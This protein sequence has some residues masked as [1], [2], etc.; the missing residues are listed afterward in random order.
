MS[1]VKK[2]LKITGYES[3]SIIYE[4]EILAGTIGDK[5]L[6]ELLRCLAS[7]YLEEDEVVESL[8]KKNSRGKRDLLDIRK[9]NKKF[10]LECGEN[11][12]FVAEIVTK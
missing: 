4:R 1:K 6:E 5:K 12:Y 7:K 11:P 10:M 3:L 9:N 2:Y 8:L